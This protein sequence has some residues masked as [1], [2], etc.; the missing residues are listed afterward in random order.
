MSDNLQVI[1]CKRTNNNAMNN[2]SP[3]LFEFYQE[4]VLMCSISRHP[5]VQSSHV[6]LKMCHSVFA[7][8]IALYPLHHLAISYKLLLLVAVSLSLSL[9]KMKLYKMKRYM[10]MYSLPFHLLVLLLKLFVVPFP[11]P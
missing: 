9:P 11:R 2:N 7:S 5:E 4:I 10:Y 6:K 1:H 3:F 8:M